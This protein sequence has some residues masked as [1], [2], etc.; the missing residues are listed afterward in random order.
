MEEKRM[1]GLAILLS[2]LILAACAGSEKFTDVVVLEFRLAEVK[3]A[4]GLTMM[5][6][7]HSGEKYYLHKEVLMTNASVARTAVITWRGH[8]A[9]EIIFTESGREEFGRLTEQNIGNR[10]GMLADSRLVAAPLINGP[11]HEGRAIIEGLFSREEA[12]RVADGIVAGSAD[13][14]F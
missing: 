1:R 4:D 12:Q 6:I 5:T 9:V 2:G 13:R 11:I 8:L 7:E 10:L 14:A 3:P